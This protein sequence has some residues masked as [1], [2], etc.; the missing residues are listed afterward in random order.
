MA[1]GRETSRRARSGSDTRRRA[2][3]RQSCAG[4]R[5]VERVLIDHVGARDVHEDRAR[6]S[7][8]PSCSG[9]SRPRVS[10]VSGSVIDEVV[11]APEHFVQDVQA[12]QEL[13]VVLAPI[14]RRRGGS[15]RPPCRR[16]GRAWP[17]PGRCG[18]S[19]GCRASGRTAPATRA[20]E[21][22]RAPTGFPR[23]RAATRRPPGRSSRLSASMAPSTYS[24]MPVSCP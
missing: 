18:R 4:E 5:L 12:S 1:G 7:C 22:R 20:A 17:R 15:R 6:A 24:A 21:P 19:R 10:A 14:A 23:C 11:R 2:R 16:R 8:R 3:R 13:Q 9:P